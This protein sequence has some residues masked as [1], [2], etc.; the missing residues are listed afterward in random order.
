[1][2]ETRTAVYPGSFDPITIGHLDVI[3]RAA[4][5]FDRLVEEP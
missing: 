3:G 5:V 2:T 4:S 1:M